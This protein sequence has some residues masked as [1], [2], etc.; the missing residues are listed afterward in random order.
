MEKQLKLLR[1]IMIGFG[2]VFL[3]VGAGIGY[4]FYTDVN[5]ENSG[6]VDYTLPIVFMCVGAM[7]ILIIT[8]ISIVIKNRAKKQQWLL[9]N[10]Q[11]IKAKLFSIE[12][13][14]RIN[15]NGRSPHVIMCQWQDPVTSQVHLFK[16]NN[17]WFNPSEFIDRSKTINVF[18]DPANMKSYVVDTSFLPVVS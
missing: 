1:Y 17:I 13:N 9:E 18:C 3:S 12:L 6:V 7:D 14:Q 16:S 11:I 2:L 4:F 15:V 10:G 8:I 5:A